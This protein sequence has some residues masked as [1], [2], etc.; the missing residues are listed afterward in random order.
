MDPQAACRVNS[1]LARS[2]HGPVQPNGVITTTTRD[3]FSA[4][5]AAV[6]TRSPLTRMSAEVAS[7]KAS[8]LTDRFE[9]LR[10]SK[11]APEPQ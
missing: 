10:Y 8:P 9:A 11:S 2:D 7:L 3:G 6:S 1:V 4:H 5:K